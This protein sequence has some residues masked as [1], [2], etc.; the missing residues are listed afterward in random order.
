[1]DLIL[2]AMTIVSLVSKGIWLHEYE[3]VFMYIPLLN[4][5]I[6]L[7]YIVLVFPCLLLQFY[8]ISGLCSH[9]FESSG[10][11]CPNAILV[12]ISEL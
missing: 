9:L 12:N 8:F 7:P 1:M 2:L 11:D 5:C 6:F 10:V 3:I 4:S